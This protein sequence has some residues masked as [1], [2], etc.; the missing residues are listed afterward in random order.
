MVRGAQ[1]RLLGH[2]LPRTRRGRFPG[3]LLGL[4]ATAAISYTPQGFAKPN[5]EAKQA[6]GAKPAAEA[7]PGPQLNSGVRR[8]D[9]EPL[10]A[11]ESSPGSA[12]GDA[13]TPS[14]S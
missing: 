11:P 1:R 6:S 14:R 13:P 3:V 10:G 9:A 2:V 4:L 8:V 5:T 12:A 7:G